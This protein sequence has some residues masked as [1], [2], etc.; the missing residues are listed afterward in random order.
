MLR[1]SPVNSTQPP[2]SVIIPVYNGEQYLAQAI[3]SVLAQTYSPVEIIIVD[4]GSTDASAQVA[5]A[6]GPPVRYVRRANSNTGKARIS[7]ST[8]ARS[9]S[10]PAHA[11]SNSVAVNGLTASE[12]ERNSL[13]MGL[14]CSRL[15][16]ISGS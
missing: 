9:S 6:Y 15:P 10:R 5:Q 7:S 8:L 4:D 14:S 3:E 16:R 12:K 13:K 2:V 1:D 11:F